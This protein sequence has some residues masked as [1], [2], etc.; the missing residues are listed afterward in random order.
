[1][2]N[3]YLAKVYNGGDGPITL[4]FDKEEDR[5][6]YLNSHDYCNEDGVATNEDIFDDGG[7]HWGIFVVKK[8]G[9]FIDAETGVEV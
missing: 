9:K 6:E 2:A 4:I 7:N 8:D 1:M 5:S 3:Y